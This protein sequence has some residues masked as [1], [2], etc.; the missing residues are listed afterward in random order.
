MQAALVGS[1]ATGTAGRRRVSGLRQL[2][3]PRLYRRQGAHEA[4]GTQQFTARAATCRQV[5]V[6]SFLIDLV[7]MLKAIRRLWI[8]GGVFEIF[9]D[10]ADALLVAA[11]EQAAATVQR[12][13]GLVDFGV[14]VQHG[15][16]PVS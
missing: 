12:L 3:E 7:H 2:G 8:H 16:P 15:A 5:A 13:F 1:L 9:A 14:F 10:H 4:A 11:A 6:E